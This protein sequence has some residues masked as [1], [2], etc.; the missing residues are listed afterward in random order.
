M[1]TIRYTITSLGELQVPDDATDEDI[2]IL[3]TEDVMDNHDEINDIEWEDAPCRRLLWVQK[4]THTK[5]L[6]TQF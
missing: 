6:D 5:K 2:E 4:I 3:I 1:K